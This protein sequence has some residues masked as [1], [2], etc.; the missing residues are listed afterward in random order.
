MDGFSAA[1]NAAP[2]I[3]PS[4]P[5]SCAPAPHPLNPPKAESEAAASLPKA[6]GPSRREIPAGPLTRVPNGDPS[7][8]TVDCPE[9]ERDRTTNAPHVEP[10]YGP[11]SSDSASSP[12]PASIDSPPRDQNPFPDIPTLEPPSESV[13]GGVKELS[14]AEPWSDPSGAISLLVP[15]VIGRPLFG[16]VVPATTKA[17]VRDAAS[18]ERAVGYELD[19]PL[20]MQDVQPDTGTNPL[21]Q[22]P[23][24]KI[25]LPV[26]EEQ[27]PAHGTEANV[28]AS[29]VPTMTQA[30]APM[31]HTSDERGPA[32]AP[33]HADSGGAPWNSVPAPKPATIDADATE[34]RLNVRTD[35]LGR[36][37]IHAAVHDSRVTTSIA[38]EDGAARGAVASE[39]SQLSRGLNS[40]ELRLETASVSIAGESN[41]GGLDFGGHGG[42]Q[43]HRNSAQLLSSESRTAPEEENEDVGEGN[44]NII[45]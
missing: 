10:L 8:S 7:P 5:S 40:H 18:P 20:G 23:P 45:V 34:L 39:F 44:L 16:A 25:D 38:V 13:N 21:Q 30:D 4:T 15:Q 27:H 28:P 19:L 3:V 22:K 41:H 1:K 12:T 2:G 17:P 24:T 29:V 31:T 14:A 43:F 32:A 42:R 9:D 37:E 6:S 36:V 11:T 35:S 33:P 26:T